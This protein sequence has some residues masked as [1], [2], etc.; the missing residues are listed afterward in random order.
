MSTFKKIKRLYFDIETSP[1][2]GLFWRPSFK[3]NI[4]H[5]QILKEREILT[6]AWKWEHED[7]VYG[8]QWDWDGEDERRDI[9]LVEQMT[10]L[11]EE[12]DE[13]VT[14]N[15]K[16]FDEKWLRTRALM[17]GL[18]PLPAVKHVDI[19]QRHR[20]YFNFN[21]N[22]QDYL[23]KLFVGEGKPGMKYQQW[24][25]MYYYGCRK[26]G[27][28]MEE[29]NRD[30]VLKLEAIDQKTRAHEPQS[31]S[32]LDLELN[33]GKCARS[34]CDGKLHKR[35]TYSTNTMSYNRYRCYECGTSYRQSNR[36]TRHGRR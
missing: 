7:Y 30:D 33:D 21:S 20:R 11:F 27:N 35:G 12:C 36:G 23:S 31:I 14:Q 19:L 6:I 3:A 13:I 4:S 26:A 25:D 9:Q 34:D 5:H 2:L 29:Y 15:G 10:E 32:T 16:S 22:C 18:P 17:L 28:E 1:N 8:M 24:V